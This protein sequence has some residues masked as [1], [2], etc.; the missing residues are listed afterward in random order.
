VKA[1][2]LS[3]DIRCIY[4]TS[5]VQVQVV[6]WEKQGILYT[7]QK[8]TINSITISITSSSWT[9]GETVHLIW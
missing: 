8:I 5:L 6:L 2:I 9:M 3:K 7:L 1:I 4:L